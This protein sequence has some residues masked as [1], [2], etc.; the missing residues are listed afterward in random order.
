MKRK[1]TGADSDNQDSDKRFFKLGNDRFPSISCIRTRCENI[2][3]STTCGNKIKKT[4]DL[5]FLQDLLKSAD[6]LKLYIGKKIK[7]I[8]K[9]KVDKTYMDKWKKKNFFIVHDTNTSWEETDYVAASRNFVDQT[10]EKY[11]SN[12]YD[13]LMSDD[14][15]YKC[16]FQCIK[17]TSLS[18][19]VYKELFNNFI[20]EHVWNLILLRNYSNLY[21]LIA[22]SSDY[23]VWKDILTPDQ[24][25]FLKKHGNIIVG[26]MLVNDELMFQGQHRKY[27]FI[28]IID[29]RVTGYGLALYMMD[30]YYLL[31]E[32]MLLP[33]II[34]APSVVYW[35]RYLNTN[36]ILPS[37]ASGTDLTILQFYKHVRA[38]IDI[39]WN[40]LLGYFKIGDMEDFAKPFWI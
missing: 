32:F 30:R 5:L 21:V 37:V 4:D 14:L 11:K 22:K 2:L 33:K 16:D 12:K 27:R 13:D 10:I 24:S 39:H 40:H 15:G 1:R 17:N 35:Y 38:K 36:I 7:K 29:S 26:V 19:E 18:Y 31:N 23:E 25:S 3:D 28:E 8:H 20:Y 34:I 6:P 9:I